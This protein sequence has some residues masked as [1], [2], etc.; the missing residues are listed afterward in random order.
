MAERRNWFSSRYTDCDDEPLC[1]ILH[2]HFGQVSTVSLEESLEYLWYLFFL[3]ENNL[4][5]CKR[6]CSNP[7]NGLSEDESASIHL[8]TMEFG[9]GPSL[10]QLL[11]KALR[12]VNQQSL[13]V[14]NHFLKLILTGLNKIP[15]SS[16]IVWRGSSQQNL[17]S[18]YPIGKQFRWW[19]LTRCTPER[20]TIEKDIHV[21]QTG[22]RTLFSI[23][24]RNGK[25][26]NQYSDG[27]DEMIFMP[28]AFFQVI[29]QTNP[30]K[31]LFIIYLQEIPP[32]NDDPPWWQTTQPIV[33]QK[34]FDGYDGNLYDA[35]REYHNSH[36]KSFESGP[37]PQLPGLVTPPLSISKHIEPIPRSGIGFL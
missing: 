28:G 3:L 34:N 25:L 30:S 26:I 9:C 24:S 4:W 33:T 15:S 23:Q 31:D 18:K 1:D 37:T 36:T 7:L 13:N 32:P 35:L 5:I 27:E 12:D 10:Y 22:V 17:C 16:Q 2:P 14:W 11:N 29:D 6:K 19:G 21:G 8:F 20:D